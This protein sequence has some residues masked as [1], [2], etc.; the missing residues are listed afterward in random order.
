MHKLHVNGEFPNFY[1]IFST[2]HREI[3]KSLKFNKYTQILK[4]CFKI[5]AF[6]GVNKLMLKSLPTVGTELAVTIA[7]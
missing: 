3:Y 2:E 7:T 6:G 1:V 5:F 4:Q